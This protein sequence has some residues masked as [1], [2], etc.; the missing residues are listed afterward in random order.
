MKMGLNTHVIH[1]RKNTHQVVNRSYLAEDGEM[2][3]LW[4][5]FY[6]VVVFVTTS[7]SEK[8]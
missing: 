5:Y 3:T 1:T 6:C 7:D 8:F 4:F 2:L